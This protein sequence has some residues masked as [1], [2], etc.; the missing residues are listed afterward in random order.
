M[1]LDGKNIVVTGG[2]G[3]IGSHLVDAL[4]KKNN[5][6]TVLDN[7]SSGKLEFLEQHEGKKHYSFVKEDLLNPDPLAKI[8][9]GA[10]CVFHLAANPDVRLGGHDTRVHLEQNVIATHN[11]LEAMRKEDVSDIY[12]TSTSTVYGETNVVPTPECHGPLE[13]ISLYGASKLACEALISAY[14]HNFTMQGLS[15]RFANVVGERSTHGVIYDFINKLKKD[16]STLEILGTDPGTSKSYV[17]IDDAITGMVHACENSDKTVDY[18][19]LGTK[20]ITTVRT[21]AEIVCKEMGLHHV[22][23]N[24]TGGVDGGRGWKGDVRLMQLSIEK[25]ER[26]GWKPNL[27]SDDAIR[28]T[29]KKLLSNS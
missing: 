23:F 20:E 11:L 6:I 4:M 25:L 18:F 22:K 28:K 26:T 10:D 14:A 17:H 24:F 7:L 27:S 12:F 8:V 21:I 16:P 2:A 29:V 1:K 19:N 5:H 9:K 3:F 15:F 13:P